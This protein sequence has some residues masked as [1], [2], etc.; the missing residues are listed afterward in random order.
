PIR[1]AGLEAT[2][3]I[4]FTGAP[5]LWR[6]HPGSWSSNPPRGEIRRD[7]L[8]IGITVP[9]QQADQAAQYIEQTVAQLPDIIAQ[10]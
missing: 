10:Q 2:K 4:P 1:V 5:E 9:A 6:L 3:S 7:K 8:V